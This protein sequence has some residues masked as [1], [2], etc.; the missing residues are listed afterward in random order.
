MP[1]ADAMMRDANDLI[2]EAFSCFVDE[3]EAVE[4]S[5]RVGCPRQMD[6]VLLH[7][8]CGRATCTE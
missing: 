2:L 8:K 7:F 6:V 5:I 4:M 1:V 3:E